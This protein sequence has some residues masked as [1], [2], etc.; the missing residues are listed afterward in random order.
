MKRIGTILLAGVL[1]L[2]MLTGCGSREEEKPEVKIVQRMEEETSETEGREEQG[3]DDKENRKRDKG[4]K[5]SI[6]DGAEILTDG[7]EEQTLEDKDVS[8]VIGG[9]K[10]RIPGEYGCFIEESKGPIV[11]RDDLFTL[12][13][14][15]RDLSYEE[16]MQ[17]PERLMEGAAKVGGEITKEIEEIEIGGR[18]YAYYKYTNEGDDFIVVYT[19]VPDSGK[20]LCAQILI[21]SEKETDEE[22]LNRWADIAASAVETDEADTTQE[23][24]EE[25][26]CLAD[27]GE[28][29]E[30]STLEYEG[31]KIAFRVEP[32]FYST[33]E[34]SD[35]VSSC[36]YFTRPDDY[37]TLD[38]S[39]T[40]G[41]GQDAETYI[42][43]Q[44]AF[45]DEENIQTGNVKV[46]AYTF[47]YA[48]TRYTS[49]GSEFQRII[50]ACS[51]DDGHIYTI[52][53]VAIDVDDRIELDDYE[54]FM[55]VEEQ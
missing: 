1:G 8:I 17:N 19:A 30:E 33:F 32:G 6:L 49:E 46:G 47:Y 45:W 40:S 44:T 21:R 43:N 37:R 31:V 35:D 38:C 13:M 9:I 15:V 26:R 2:G 55:K 25:A 41:Y 50:A 20:R 18:K 23:S 48:E 12:L 34:D 54:N 4:E 36:E 39:L 27:F 5:E 53:A 24:L 7:E 28:E 10:V 11:Y 16:A 14:A 22:L 52:S 42:E 29:K 3:N 51:I